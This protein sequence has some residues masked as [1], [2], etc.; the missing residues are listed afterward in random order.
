VKKEPGVSGGTEMDDRSKVDV[1]GEK[2]GG[3]PQ[4]CEAHSAKFYEKT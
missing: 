2:K 4:N 1:T 3:H